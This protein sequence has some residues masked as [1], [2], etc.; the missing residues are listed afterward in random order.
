MDAKQGYSLSVQQTPPTKS[1][2]ETNRIDSYLEHLQATYAYL[3]KLA[4][5]V[6]GD[7]FYSKIKWVN[8]VT[9]LHL[10]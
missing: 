9:D 4:R 2:P 1:S 8:G 5:Y 3:P 6:V 7:G 10:D